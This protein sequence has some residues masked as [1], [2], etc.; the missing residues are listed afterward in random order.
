MHEK[1][2]EWN[3]EKWKSFKLHKTEM[4]MKF[5]IF[6][7]QMKFLEIWNE[8]G[9]FQRIWNE[10]AFEIHWKCHRDKVFDSNIKILHW[11]RHSKLV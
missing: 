7:M 1:L 6:K 4:Q 5:A 11:W 9:N 8:N 2:K 10:I 3:L